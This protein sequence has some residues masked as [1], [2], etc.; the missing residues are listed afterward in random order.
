MHSS[1]SAEFSWRTTL[2]SYLF[3]SS[4]RVVLRGLHYEVCAVLLLY[5]TALSNF[6]AAAVTSLGNY[7]LDKTLL[8]ADRKRKDDTLKWAADTFCKAAGIFEYLSEQMIPAWEA[9]VGRI[10]GRPPDLTKEVTIALSK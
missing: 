3:K 5:G 8:A 10:D 4:P 9:Q 6:A 7:E 2:S 1:P